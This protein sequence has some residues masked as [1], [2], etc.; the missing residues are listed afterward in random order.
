MEQTLSPLRR[1]AHAHGFT[2]ARLARVSG[3]SEYRTYQGSKGWLAFRPE[4]VESFARALDIEP[5]EI[6]NGGG[7]PDVTQ[8]PAE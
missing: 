1:L 2:L 3:V 4:E 6:P 7:A 5:K 8:P